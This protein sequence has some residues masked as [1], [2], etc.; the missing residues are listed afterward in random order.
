[1]W[2]VTPMASSRAPRI[3]RPVSSTRRVNVLSPGQDIQ[4]LEVREKNMSNSAVYTISV[5]YNLGYL[6]DCQI[7]A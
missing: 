2:L 1:M 4:S 3:V 7:S 6:L 5:G